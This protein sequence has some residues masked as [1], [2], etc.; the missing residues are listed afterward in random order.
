MYIYIY[1]YVY[2]TAG[3][4]ERPID[5]VF[6]VE[7]AS[8]HG[9]GRGT[10]FHMGKTCCFKNPSFQNLAFSILYLGLFAICLAYFLK[11]LVLKQQVFPHIDLRGHANPP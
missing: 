4:A 5:G 11:R 6:G 9:L 1:I 2:H 3:W 8:L 7:A 10:I